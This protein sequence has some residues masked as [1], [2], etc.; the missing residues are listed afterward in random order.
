M[1]AFTEF[2]S[3]HNSLAALLTRPI[4]TAHKQMY[5]L[6]YVEHELISCYMRY[7]LQFLFQL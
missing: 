3:V 7:L 6:L 1:V 5:R 2:T 4:A